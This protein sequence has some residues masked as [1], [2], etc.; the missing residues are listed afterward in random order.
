MEPDLA[1]AQSAHSPAVAG[2]L[3]ERL[4]MDQPFFWRNSKIAPPCF[5]TVSGAGADAQLH[6]VKR[7]HARKFLADAADRQDAVT[8]DRRVN[9]VDGGRCC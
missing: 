2:L 8:L 9:A 6:I 7:Q 4:C 3:T 5:A 1:I